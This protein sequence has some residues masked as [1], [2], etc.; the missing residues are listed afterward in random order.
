MMMLIL[1]AENVFLLFACVPGVAL[2][3]SFACSLLE[4]SRSPTANKPKSCITIILGLYVE[5]NE[6]IERQSQS[7]KSHES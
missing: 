7:L 3:L 4:T 5:P 6:V 2:L 1:I